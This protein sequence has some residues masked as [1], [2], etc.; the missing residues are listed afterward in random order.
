MVSAWGYLYS[1]LGLQLHSIDLCVCFCATNILFNYYGSVI[2]SLCL[3]IGELRPF[4][5]KVIIEVRV[6]IVLV[7]S[8]GFGGAVSVSSGTSY[9]NN[10]DFIF[11]L[12]TISV[13]LIPLYSLKYCF[14]CYL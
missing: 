12:P 9:F 3:L 14:L 7:L 1:H 10:Y 2:Y 13:M 11:P 6:L 8:L 4:I 5:F